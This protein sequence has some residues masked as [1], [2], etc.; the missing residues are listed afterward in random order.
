MLGHEYCIVASR[1]DMKAVGNV[2]CCKKL[3]HLLCTRVEAVI[4]VIASVVYDY[5]LLGIGLRYGDCRNVAGSL[6]GPARRAFWEAYGDPDEREVA[7]DSPVSVLYTLSLAVRLPRLP[8]W[9]LAC[10]PDPIRA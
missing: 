10:Q 6:P 8:A 2:A 3:I 9:A 4:I 5:H 7:L 1:I